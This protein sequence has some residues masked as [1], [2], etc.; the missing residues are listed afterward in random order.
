MF[1]VISGVAKGPSSPPPKQNPVVPEQV[2]ANTGLSTLFT[3][4]IQFW[5]ASL[6]RWSSEHGVDVNLAATV[7]QIE[8]CG[9][10]DARSSSGAMGLFQVMPFHFL[11][12]EN[13]YNT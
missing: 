13:G 8:S 4:E 10:P 2:A 7:M 9:N 5:A 1:F 12:N 6:K 11:G 3:P